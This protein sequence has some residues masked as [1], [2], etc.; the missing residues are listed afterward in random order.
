[1]QERISTLQASLYNNVRIALGNVTCAD[2]KL[3]WRV[4]MLAVMTKQLS[5]VQKS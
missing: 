2:C 5:D 3:G 4:K 1:M